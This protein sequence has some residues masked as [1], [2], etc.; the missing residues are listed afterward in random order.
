MA[1]AV[2]LDMSAVDRH[3]GKEVL[4][5]R[6]EVLPLVRLGTVMRTVG[7]G[8]EQAAVIA[9]LGER[10]TALAVDELVGREQIDLCAVIALRS[11]EPMKID[12]ANSLRRRHLLSRLRTP[13]WGNR[14]RCGDNL[15]RKSNAAA[16]Q[17]RD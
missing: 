6:D 11:D 5:L 17:C 14:S 13:L 12:R 15:V 8:R 2:Q 4:R 16:A 10:R 3:K 9:E 1:E 7:A